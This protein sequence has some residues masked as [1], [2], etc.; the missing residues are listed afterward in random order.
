[1]NDNIKTGADIN[2]GDGGYNE[3]TKEKYDEFVKGRNQ[4]LGKMRIKELADKAIED[5]PGSWN[6]PDEFCK[7]F[8]ELIVQ[9][10]ANHCDLLLDHKISSEWSRGT[11]DCS[12]AIKKHFGVE[13]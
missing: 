6:I 5:M 3:S 8:A 10:C 11:H 12:R 7:K 9:E 2:A 13:L 1:M 4:S